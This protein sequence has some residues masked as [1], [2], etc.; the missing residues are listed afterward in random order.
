MADDYRSIATRPRRKNILVVTNP[1]DDDSSSDDSNN[2]P[3]SYYSSQPPIYNNYHPTIPP[4]PASRSPALENVSLPPSSHHP[5]PL[6][7]K[8]QD[9]A[10]LYNSSRSNPALSS[11]SSTSSPAVEST[12]PPS[13]PGQSI[14]P[15]DLAGD[16][17]QRQEPQIAPMPNERNEPSAQQNRDI[18]GSRTNLLDKI[19]SHL[20][21]PSR[22]ARRP[23][24]TSRATTSP[25]ATTPDSYTSSPRSANAE[26]RAVLVTT[27]ADN[28]VRVDISGARSPDYI[29]ERIFTHLRI[30]DD[31][32]DQFS[33]YLT[34]FGAFA[35]GDA[36]SDDQI[37]DICMN[38]G[39]A[40]GSLIFFVSHGSAA[41]HES[42]SNQASPTVNTI[43]PPILPN[44]GYPT[45][46]R[47]RPG[48]GSRHDSQ[49]SLS[50]RLQPDVA[51]G[52]EPSVSDDL[53][54]GES[55]GTLR[56]PVRQIN[57]GPQIS[58]GFV[59]P[60]PVGGHRAPSLP[61][62]APLRPVSPVPQPTTRPLSPPESSS[63]LRSRVRGPDYDRYGGP[64]PVL[65]TPSTSSN[66]SK[67][68]FLEDNTP[69]PSTYRP[70]HFR[71]G[72][73]AAAERERA[74][75][76]S[77][78]Q[79]DYA[80]R[81][82]RQKRNERD[83][84]GGAGTGSKCLTDRAREKFQDTEYGDGDRK[85][86]GDPWV[87]VPRDVPST[88]YGYPKVR[89]T[90]GPDSNRAPPP[91]SI[92]RPLMR[93]REYRPSRYQ[94]GPGPSPSR[95]PIPNPPRNPPPPPPIGA[96]EPRMTSQGR[97]VGQTVPPSWVVSY[98]S[99]P[100]SD[101]KPQPPPPPPPPP[102]TNIWNRLNS[103][104]SMGDIGAAYRQQVPTALQPGARRPK[105]PMSGQPSA[106]SSTSYLPDHSP[107][108]SRDGGMPGSLPKSYDPLRNAF[109][110]NYGSRPLAPMATS[111]S[112]YESGAGGRQ[113]NYP[114][115]PPSPSVNFSSMLTPS[116]DPYARPSS[117]LGDITSSPSTQRPERR[118]QSL[119]WNEPDSSHE[120][121]T[122]R[123]RQNTA[124]LQRTNAYAS[125]DDTPEPRSAAGFG[126]KLHINPSALYDRP[127][128]I[129][130]GLAEPSSSSYIHHTPP[131]SPI[132]PLSPR[133]RSPNR[134]S[135]HS[136]PAM[137]TSDL[138][139]QVHLEAEDSPDGTMK[140]GQ[141]EWM[142]KVFD[143]AEST[144]VPPVP[145][146]D[147]PSSSQSIISASSLQT[148][149]S[150]YSGFDGSTFITMDNESFAGDDDSDSGDDAGTGLWKRP[151]LKL[152]THNI[153][154][155]PPPTQA[156]PTA[157]PKPEFS[158]RKPRPDSIFITNPEDTWA[159]RPP[160]EDVYERLEEFFPGHDLD[161]PVIEASS[162]GTS[163][164]STDYPIPPLPTIEA[165][166]KR[167]K[168]KKSIRVV[169]AEHKK[170][171]DRTSRMEAAL[172][173]S[174]VRRHRSTKLWDSKTEEVTT[175][176]LKSIASGPDSPSPS[177]PK[178]IFKWVRGELIGKGTYGR[179]YL[180]LN[181]TTGEMIAVKQVEIPRTA[182]DKND[183]RQ[184]TIVQALKQESET[185]KDLDHPNIVQYLG[186]EETPTHLSIFLE[187]VPGGSIG[188]CLKKHGKFDEN[189]TKS[190]TGQILGGLAYLHSKGIL[191]RD[192]KADNILVETSGICK[193]SD[194][195]I[196]KRT[197]DVNVNGA[198]TAMQGS[199][200]WM[201][202][203][204]I[205][206]KEKGY[207][208]KIDIW[209]VGCVVLEM[210]A[211]ERPWSSEEMV[212][213]MFKLYGKTT[214]PV[215]ADVHLSP[216][217]EDFRKR[218]FAVNPDE[219]PNATELRQ[220]P[221]LTLPPGWT[222]TGFK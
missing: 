118:V 79:L 65:Q 47:S 184:V 201:A 106:M 58:Q 209:S 191:H 162:G 165:P 24:S 205:N 90:T 20:P 187:Y 132:S 66:L 55:R 121:A 107:T 188:S 214:P 153:P 18:P 135:G 19:K 110:P 80:D 166:E 78:N 180:A 45:P 81:L 36:L 163:P 27:D 167:F 148:S 117:A 119:P 22:H 93:D 1:G 144:V 138:S 77:E 120:T 13:T 160:P 210:W 126:S 108:N 155:T 141:R 17:P 57:S 206:S 109:P 143:S 159:V 8:L 60:S 194:F 46:G 181:A 142:S 103:T 171:I 128:D 15:V 98:K 212:A 219:R 92:S 10:H 64:T 63:P 86:Q 130:G 127:S 43:P 39:D 37:F 195:G 16:A 113:V 44:R 32:Q 202:P 183:S 104:K 203:E 198:F 173:N 161:K 145:K 222:F 26:R 196:S 4:S 216:L 5:P 208:A 102:P 101:S 174:N 152:E 99:P 221:Y 68:P 207:N 95:L 211:G 97:P 123:P 34:E 133:F 172:S 87:V 41:V 134:F 3:S 71:S 129:Y 74:L 164:T 197:D 38:R 28:Y 25:T 175:E 69:T 213:V 217:A 85:I 6:N 193:I 94:T 89:P 73:D 75:Q 156:I 218:C 33:I 136:E 21:H 192:M 12:P 178:P 62:L 76:E 50:E 168:H 53:N 11:P 124:Q 114:G 190:F 59:P 140:Q 186:F 139:R 72:S 137:P 179:V 100:K 30:A 52:Y 170:K 204:V 220:H 122:L 176:K 70:T 29:R 96:A 112:S 182:S 116:Q 83:Y 54:D 146:K 14:P 61:P 7:T 149:S 67:F 84:R 51:A 2:V 151:P 40:K 189:V 105:L 199:V 82:W 111:Q 200:F 157:T 42:H 154:P 9:H 125:R 49:S 158:G 35:M 23:S 91:L 169:A 185:L 131:R 31:D 215:P 48:P 177:G 147:W 150:A 115:R 88:S 56:P